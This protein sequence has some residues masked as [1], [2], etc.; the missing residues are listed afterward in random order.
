MV[1]RIAGNREREGG[2]DR[3]DRGAPSRDRAENPAAID[4]DSPR[5]E[6]LPN[7]R[8][9]RK[10]QRGVEAELRAAPGIRVYARKRSPRETSGTNAINES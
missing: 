4:A 1:S 9:P 10:K 8:A 5:E 7:A 2:R 3:S 6:H